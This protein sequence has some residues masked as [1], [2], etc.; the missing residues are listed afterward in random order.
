MAILLALAAAAV[1]GSGDFFGG[2][3]SRHGRVLAVSLWVH[4]CGVAA[5]LV[6]GPLVG[7]DPT[8]ADLWWGAAA[9][10][11]GAV[12]VTSLYLGFASSRMGVVAPVSAVVAA[13]V[14]VMFG[15]ATGERP[16]ALA[17]GGLGLGLVAIA[18]VSRPGRDQGSAGVAAGV[19]RGLAAGAAFGA[20][21]VFFGQVGDGTGVWPVLPARM[22]GAA[23]LVAVA[24]GTRAPG[25]PETASWPA[26]GLAALLTAGGNGLFVL[27]SQ[28]GLLAVVSVLTSMYPAAT[29]AWARVVYRERLTGMQLAGVALALAA[30]ALIAGG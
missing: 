18:L 27:A 12:G 19:L 14:P 5:M 7:G 21:F 20:L 16:A 6:L 10:L 30:I 26:I 11:A 28:E 4:V 29:V 15:L 1:V 13:A 9:G 2:M 24:V 23:L 8:A 3:A 25:R 17:V 22:A